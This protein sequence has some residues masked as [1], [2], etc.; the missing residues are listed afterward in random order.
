[1]MHSPQGAC[2]GKMARAP[3]LQD[4]NDSGKEFDHGAAPQ[5]NDNNATIAS[6]PFA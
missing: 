3:F 1:M 5:R 4:L 2:T 6:V